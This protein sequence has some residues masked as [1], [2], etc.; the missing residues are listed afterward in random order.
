MKR[1]LSWFLLRRKVLKLLIFLILRR[2]HFKN[3]SSLFK[4]HLTSMN[5]VL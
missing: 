3:L 4:K 1:C 5:L 2:K